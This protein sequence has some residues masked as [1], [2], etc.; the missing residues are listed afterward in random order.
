M[1]GH[2]F[3]YLPLLSITVLPLASVGCVGFIA[4]DGDDEVGETGDTAD[5]ADTADTSTGDGDG[6][7]TTIYEIQEGAA[8]GSFPDKT[9]VQLSGVVVTSPFV[10]EDSL[11]FVEEPAGGPWSGI[12]L[13]LW[14]EV[15]MAVQLQPG[16]VI[17]VVGEYTEFFEMSQIV[18]KS[19][20][21]ITVSSSGAALPGPDV[22]AVGEAGQEQWEGVLVRVEDAV[23]AEANDGFGQ[24]LLEG[25]LKVGNLFLGQLPQ[26][27][28][29]RELRVDHRAD[30]LLVQRVQ[31]PADAGVGSGRLHGP[32]RADGRHVDLRHPSRC[33]RRG[34]L[35]QGRGRD[36]QLGPDLVRRHERVVLRAGARWRRAL[37]HP[38]VRRRHH[39]ALDRARRRGHARRH[40]RGV[41]RHEPGRRRRRG[42]GDDHRH[43]HRR[44][45]HFEV[46]A[47]ETS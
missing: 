23:V 16:D 20:T 11:V 41:L 42:G 30:A 36:R 14:D 40:L 25:G 10:A 3:S 43:H 13:Y 1:L 32:R 24:Y 21:D 2:R 44:N 5:T 26:A 35:H 47:G 38:G 29:G 28:M 15:A 18:V 22:V 39:R 31:G 33:R 34:Q 17:D 37:G 19:P 46:F 9:L 6:D 4:N 8:N 7:A 27:Q 45:Q 12:S